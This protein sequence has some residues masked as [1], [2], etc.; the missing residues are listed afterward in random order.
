MLRYIVKDDPL[1]EE[2]S[3]GQDRDVIFAAGGYLGEGALA[4]FLRSGRT[5]STATATST[6]SSCSW[7][8]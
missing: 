6:T 3:I 8:R 1:G 5:R 4:N 2:E 7:T